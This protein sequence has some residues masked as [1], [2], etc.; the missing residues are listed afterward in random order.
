[1]AATGNEKSPTRVASP[2]DVETEPFSRF[3]VQLRNVTSHLALSRT[4]IQTMICDW[5]LTQTTIP[6]RSRN[7]ARKT[8][9]G[10]EFEKRAALYRFGNALLQV[11]DAL[12]SANA[13]LYNN[14]HEE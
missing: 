14:Q 9:V 7:N 8:Q 2:E 5:S 4:P 1:M 12:A 13:D 10:L 11:H 6:I 3:Q